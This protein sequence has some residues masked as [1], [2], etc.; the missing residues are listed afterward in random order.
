MHALHT[1][2]MDVLGFTF[3]Q[4]LLLD[5]LHIEE[6][7]TCGCSACPVLGIPGFKYLPA[8]FATHVHV[9][10]VRR[11]VGGWKLWGSLMEN[12][13]SCWPCINQ[14]SVSGQICRN[15]IEFKCLAVFA[16]ASICFIENDAN[17]KPS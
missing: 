2:F 9:K 15:Y 14:I 10:N 3:H 6:D 7:L 11:W 5:T 17:T 1:L 13:T 8:H 12:P 16:N 4:H